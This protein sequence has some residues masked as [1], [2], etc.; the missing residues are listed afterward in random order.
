MNKITNS[1]WLGMLSALFFTALSIAAIVTQEITIFYVIYVF[2]WDELIK[3]IFEASKLIFNRGQIE[4]VFSFKT[5]VG[6]RMFMLF[7][8]FVFIV[9]CFGLIIDWNF[10]EQISKNFDVFLFQNIFF[11]LSLITFIGR[12]VYV[13]ANTYTS[14]V[15]AGNVFSRGAMT[16]H[17]SI[18]LGLLLWAVSTNKIGSFMPEA[19][20]KYSYIAAV[21]P[22]FIIKFIFDW[23]ELKSK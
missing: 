5:M 4:D 12:E 6:A 20:F 3:V 14:K 18:I 1:F 8:Y 15:E 10:K 23:W 2:W 17:L 16:L 19:F 7:I 9:L 22:F 11:N 21:V 13:Y